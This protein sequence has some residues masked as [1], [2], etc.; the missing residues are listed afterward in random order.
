MR[1]IHED[2]TTEKPSGSGIGSEEYPT[3]TVFFF[4]DFAV[5]ETADANAAQTHATEGEDEP[6]ETATTGVAEFPIGSPETPEGASVSGSENAG[7]YE[8]LSA[9]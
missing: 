7:K 5:L 2:G 3:G 9:E 4:E 1:S 8:I 6:E